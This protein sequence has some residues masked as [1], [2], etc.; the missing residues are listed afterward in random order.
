M[1][2]LKGW[3]GEKKT[4]LRMWIFL[5]NKTYK[6]FH[7]IILPS[8]NGTTQIDHLIVTP[9]GIFIIETKNKKGWIFGSAH[10]STWTQSIYGNNYTFQNPLKQ[11]YRQTKILAGF[12]D[13]EESA[14]H[15][16]VYFAGDCTFK[17]KLPSN[18]I[19]SRLSR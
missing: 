7:N 8:P 16:V 6:R 11:T 9:F 15:S 4:A 14:I 19:K 2:I 13:I 18:I 1:N 5:N 17:T 12:L 3:L 10:R